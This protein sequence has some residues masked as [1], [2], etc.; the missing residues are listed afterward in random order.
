MRRGVG[1][2]VFFVKK[3]A[4]PGIVRDSGTFSSKEGA[5]AVAGSV[6]GRGRNVPFPTGYRLARMLRTQT[7][8]MFADFTSMM[9]RVRCQVRCMMAVPRRRVD[10]PRDSFVVPSFFCFVFLCENFHSLV[11]T[12]SRPLRGGKEGSVCRAM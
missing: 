3:F 10:I 8:T 7:V 2:R 9:T 12:Q 6:D 5:D 11:G 1:G 4:I